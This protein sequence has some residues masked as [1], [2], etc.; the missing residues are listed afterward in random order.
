M[1]GMQ[2]TPSLPFF[3]GHSWT[4]GQ[5]CQLPCPTN[6]SPALELLHVEAT[7]GLCEWGGSEVEAL[8]GAHTQ[9]LIP[10]RPGQNQGLTDLL[11]D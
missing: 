2:L 10:I 11:G 7:Q 3:L 8:G 6:S 9:V 4:D 1:R 5:V